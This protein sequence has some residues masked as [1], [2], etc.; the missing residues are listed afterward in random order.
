MYIICLFIC[1]VDKSLLHDYK[2]SIVNNSS[3]AEPFFP[4]FIGMVAFTLHRVWNVYHCKG[5]I[6]DIYIQRHKMTMK[7]KFTLILGFVQT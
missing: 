3:Y 5:S 2:Y 6:F 4:L 7:E 1:I